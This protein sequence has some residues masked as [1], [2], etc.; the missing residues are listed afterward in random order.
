MVG[1]WSGAIVGIKEQ[2]ELP[3][4]RPAV[5]MVVTMQRPKRM[6]VRSVQIANVK[7][8][9]T[10][11]GTQHSGEQVWEIGVAMIGVWVVRSGT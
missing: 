2:L 8:W 7:P 10:P 4:P 6:P 9:G 11:W 5:R 1:Y 3:V